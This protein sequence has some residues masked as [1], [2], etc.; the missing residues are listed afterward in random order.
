MLGAGWYARHREQQRRRALKL[1]RSLSWPRLQ[2]GD[3][4]GGDGDGD[5]DG[6]ESGTGYGGGEGGHGERGTLLS[7]RVMRSHAASAAARKSPLAAELASKLLAWEVAFEVRRSLL[8][9]ERQQQEERVRKA[10]ER[11][12]DKAAKLAAA[13]SGKRVPG[14]AGAAK[15]GGKTDGSPPGAAQK[16]TKAPRPPP[17][18]TP[19]T[20][21]AT[22]PDSS[23]TPRAAAGRTHGAGTAAGSG[24]AAAAARVRLPPP[25]P[26]PAPRRPKALPSAA[27]ATTAA[28]PGPATATPAAAAASGGTS[29]GVDAVGGEGGGAASESGGPPARPALGRSSS[30]GIRG[31]FSDASRL[32][33]KA[34][35]IEAAAKAA[36]GGTGD[37]DGD[38]GAAGAYAS[39][40]EGHPHGAGSEG[41]NSQ[42]RARY[43]GVGVGAGSPS[44]SGRPQPACA[45]RLNRPAPPP[46]PLYERG[47]G[48][49]SSS[50]GSS[51]TRPG[52]AAAAVRPTGEGADK[53][54][55]K[56]VKSLG[57]NRSDGIE[58]AAPRRRALHQNLWTAA[59]RAV[60]RCPLIV[61]EGVA[62]DS[63]ALEVAL[64]PL[65]EVF[66]LETADLDASTRRALVTDSPVV[67]APPLGWVTMAKDDQE[68]LVPV[69]YEWARETNVGAFYTSS[70]TREHGRYDRGQP[71]ADGADSPIHSPHSS[72]ARSGRQR[73]GSGSAANSDRA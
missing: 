18:P 22:T 32:V 27:P 67:G 36:L 51:Y 47:I 34:L 15:A 48:G 33:R 20:A 12:A 23:R 30:F 64:D 21:S 4:G 11:A 10:A 57:P 17:P 60:A 29:Q 13:A 8:T 19:V 72:S 40:E 61:R 55:A 52:D 3:G 14:K 39:Q 45:S 50:R 42:A 37:G 25:A 58:E 28:G 49:H 69:A 56:F 24:S 65:S 31:R 16:A 46:L 5:G 53:R 62:L 63:P 6:D 7:R 9:R 43:G 73:G 70:T 44:L 59:P 66:V 2:S 35:R 38:G 26:L 41:G 54:W 71:R 1:G 68:M